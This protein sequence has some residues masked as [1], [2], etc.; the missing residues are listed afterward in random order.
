MLAGAA[1]VD[2]GIAG[3][4]WM[5]SEDAWMGVEPE[6]KKKRTEVKREGRQGVISFVDYPHAAPPLH[7]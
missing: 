7:F 3:K 4:N 2:C 6:N 1:G 5:G